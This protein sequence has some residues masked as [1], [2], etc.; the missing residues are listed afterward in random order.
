VTLVAAPGGEVDFANVW[1]NGADTTAGVTVGDA[2]HTGTVKFLGANTYGGGTTVAYGTLQV[3]NTTGSGTGSGTVSVNSGATL[4]GSG[5]IAGNVFVAGA[6]LPG[7][8]GLTNTIGGNLTYSGGAQANFDLSSSAAN[9]GNDQIVLNGTGGNL[10]GNSVNVGINCGPYLD[11]AHSYVLFNLTGSGATSANILSGFNATP[12]WLGTTPSQASNYQIQQS[13][14]QVLLVY[15]GPAPPTIT[16]G[17]VTPASAEH[18]QPVVVSVT[19]T[20]GASSINPNTGVTVNLTSINGTASQPLIADGLGDYTNTVAAAYNLYAGAYSLPVSVA[21]SGGGFTSTNLTLTVTTGSQVWNGGDVG[22]SSN[23]SDNGNWTSGFA[24]GYGDTLAFAGTV[25]LSPVMNNSYTNASLTFNGGA[26]SFTIA[27]SGGST[28]TLAGTVVNVAN[29]SAN[30]ETLNVPVVFN[31]TATDSL[32]AVSGNLTLGQTINNSGNLL[33]VADSGFN[34]TVGGTISGGGGLT[35]S[36]AGTLTLNGNNSFTGATTITSG[37]LTIGGSGQLGGGTYSQT[38]ADTGILNYNGSA[39]QT[40]SGIISGT[41]ALTQN[42][43]GSL[44]LSV[45]NTYS[46]GTTNNSGVLVVQ[47]NSAALGTGSVIVNGGAVMLSSNGFTAYTLANAFFFTNTSLIDMN[48]STASQVFSGALSGSGTVIVTNMD[49]VT[50]ATLQTLTLGAASASSTMNAF[51]GHLAVQGMN[52]DGLISQGSLRFNNGTTAFNFG[53]SNAS[54]NLGTGVVTLTSRDG[55][56][57]DL[58]ELVGGQSTVLLGSRSTAGTTIWRVGGLNTSTTFAGSISNYAAA[59]ISALTKFGTGTLILTGTNTDGNASTTTNG[60]TGPI[61]VLAG[62]LQIGDGNADGTLTSGGVT[63]TLP[64]ILAFDR[65]DTYTVTNPITG[66]GAV[67]MIGNGTITLNPVGAANTYTGGTTI[68]SGTLALSAGGSLASSPISVAGGATFDITALASPLA[69]ASSQ[70]LSNNASATGIIKGS[71]TTSSG[72]IVSLSFVSGTPSLTV[73]SGTLTLNS[74]TVFKVNNTG[75]ALTT[76]NYKLISSTGGTVAASGGLPAVTVG[77]AGVVSGTTTLNISGGELYLSVNP[78]ASSFTVSATIG[79]PVTLPVNPKFAWDTDGN[80]LTLAIA[81]APAAGN[82]ATVDGTGSNIIYT[83]T[84]GTSDSFTYT[85]TDAAKGVAA[86]GSV[87]VN[88]NPTGQSYNSLTPPVPNGSGQVTMSF[89]GIPGDNYA[90]DWTQ[91]LTPPVVWVPLITNTAAANGILL[92]TN[93]PSGGN[94]F[95]RTR[96]VS[97]P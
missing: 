78:V 6:T 37:V 41:G 10:T 22:N 38:I 87:T 29:N 15:S 65:P 50:A 60:P 83:A 16:A 43:T 62:T 9:G 55:G 36:G 76:G 40:L 70:T 33:T 77:G 39:A 42:G 92:F 3:N 97:H 54:F 30:A 68:S 11:Q 49:N 63:V 12:V 7:A 35:K 80:P 48:H 53:S 44:T 59:N 64:G 14:T 96:F 8:T 1:A 13:G 90:L 31:G 67:N 79:T 91:S 27:N 73:S 85:A 66:S 34:T 94:D 61:V 82:T 52:A 95:Y 28:L 25:G 74:G 51:S 72:S 81:S 47:T 17:S 58:G 2:A 19:V 71:V 20:P 89:A 88:I 4:G 26:G 21:D 24:P 45:A 32:N 56:T 5:T 93:T 86:T 57:I 84:S 18:N 23:W 75:T 46:G 69:L